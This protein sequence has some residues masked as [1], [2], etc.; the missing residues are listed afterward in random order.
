MGEVLGA[1]IVDACPHC[2]TAL[3]HWDVKALRCPQ[4][5]E[6]FMEAALKPAGKFGSS[7]EEARIHATG[8]LGDLY[9]V[10]LADAEL[11]PRIVR[12][13]TGVKIAS[14]AA[15]CSRSLAVSAEGNALAVTH[16]AAQLG[17]LDGQLAQV[18]FGATHLAALTL[19]GQ[20]PAESRGAPNSGRPPVAR[21]ERR[22]EGRAIGRSAGASPRRWLA[23]RPPFLPL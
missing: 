13:L 1:T 16:T 15:G 7:G 21:S 22:L 6:A 8:E 9:I 10:S 18:S 23:G 4:C 11:Q 14:I 12:E 20:V 2:A 5:D 19:G 17:P 3:D